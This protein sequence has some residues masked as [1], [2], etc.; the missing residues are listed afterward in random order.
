MLLYYLR[1]VQEVLIVNQFVDISRSR[2]ALIMSPGSPDD[3]RS[4]ILKKIMFI[5]GRG[6]P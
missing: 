3:K 4:L 5:P 2:R 1:N 6:V